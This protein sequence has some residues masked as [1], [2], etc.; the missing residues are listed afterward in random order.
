[1]LVFVYI[2]KVVTYRKKKTLS[3]VNMNGRGIFRTLSNIY[4]SDFSQKVS[5]WIFDSVLN[6]HIIV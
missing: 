2:E 6:T 4:D 3:K 1:M 5:S